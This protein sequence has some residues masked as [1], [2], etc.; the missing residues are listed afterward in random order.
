VTETFFSATE[1]EEVKNKEEEKKVE[2]IELDGFI[3]ANPANPVNLPELV[4]GMWVNCW[5]GIGQITHTTVNRVDVDVLG[6]I[7]HISGENIRHITPRKESEVQ[8]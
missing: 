8:V 4:A 2:N 5:A 1:D 7:Y 6:K 3:P